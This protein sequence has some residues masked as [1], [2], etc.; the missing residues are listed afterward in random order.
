MILSLQS[1]FKD[2]RIREHESFD[3]LYMRLLIIVKQAA[4]I[5]QVFT[6]VDIVRK[7]I[8]VLPRKIFGS[9]LDA[10]IENPADMR[11]ITANTLVSKL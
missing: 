5:G 6:S 8:C 10:I 4:R 3:E 1:K 11:T 2:L 7:I 9:K